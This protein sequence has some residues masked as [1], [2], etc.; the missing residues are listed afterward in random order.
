[1]E[2][3]SII[4]SGR[5]AG[6]LAIALSRA[7]YRID[8]VV[9]HI[10]LPANLAPHLD[11]AT[12]FVRLDE[13][14]AVDSDIA[15]I[16]VADTAIAETAAAIA[17]VLR[18]GSVLL[19]TSGALSS[20]ILSAAVDRGVDIGSMHPLVS[21]SDQVAGADAFTGA[22]FCVEGT[23]K[24]AAAAH[25]M[26]SSLKATA[27]SIESRF[28]PLYHA[29]AVLASGHLTTLFSAAVR[30]LSEC[31]VAPDEARK[32]LLPLAASALRN[33]RDQPPESA[34]TGPFAR[35]DLEAL[36]RHLESFDEA[37]LG[38]ERTLYL[39]LGL[40][41]LEL[42]ELG[43]GDAEKLADLRDAIKLAQ[44]SAR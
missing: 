18:P 33:L 44:G 42:A 27:F 13:L 17:R 19:H 39:E 40:A 30:S 10:N 16:S 20:E 37:G 24:A 22:Y 3:I 32:I 12:A 7:D 25:R 4:G 2:R 23:E 31:G 1:M 41:A 38:R 36:D 9:Y 29:A 6:A 43:G 28:K 8:Q 14:S 21:V 5:L 26:A 35:A 15:I 34:L 11:A